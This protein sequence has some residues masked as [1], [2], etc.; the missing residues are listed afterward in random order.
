MSIDGF[1]EPFCKNYPSLRVLEYNHPVLDSSQ[2]LLKTLE[3]N[4]QLIRFKLGVARLDNS[5]T[6]H[7]IHHLINL[8]NLA[9]YDNASISQGSSLIYLN[10]SQH[11]KIKALDLTWSRLS[12]C[13]INS[14]LFNCPDLEELMLIFYRKFLIQNDI[15]NLNLAKP[16]KIKKLRIIC[17]N[18]SE[19]SLDSILLSSPHLKELDIELNRTWKE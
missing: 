15:I 9:I 7:I 2:S 12:I 4:P 11:T 10:F 17:S 6:N 16:T 3:F 8:E 18:L 19:T 1:L 14:I 5:L 13:S